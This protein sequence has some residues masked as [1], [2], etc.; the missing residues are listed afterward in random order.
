MSSHTS[1]L[2]QIRPPAVAQ[3]NEAGARVMKAKCESGASSGLAGV[4]LL[5]LQGIIRTQ[6]PEFNRC[7]RGCPLVSGGARGEDVAAQLVCDPRLNLFQAAYRRWRMTAPWKPDFRRS[8]QP[9]RNLCVCLLRQRDPHRASRQEDMEYQLVRLV[10]FSRNMME[11][12]PDAVLAQIND[13][14]ATGR[15][16]NARNNITGALLFNSG[17]FA[18]VL[19]GRR[20]DVEETFRRIQA[21]KRHRDIQLLGVEKIETRFFPVWS[22][23][24]LGKSRADQKLFGHMAEE[25][26]L[27]RHRIER[28]SFLKTLLEIAADEEAA[29]LA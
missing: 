29:A 28:A 27:D 9:I 21:D 8:A 11:G 14:L 17:V 15:R 24:F 12:G 26:G 16:N 25:T 18:Q 13:I 19:E 20:A 1:R 4:R 10:Y 2:G 5:G 3:A 6:L 22:V 7:D 23:G